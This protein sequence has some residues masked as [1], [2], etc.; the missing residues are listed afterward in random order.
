[1]SNIIYAIQS[2]ALIVLG[3]LPVVALSTA[4]AAT[5]F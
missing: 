5:F 2:V 1:M 3:A 4:N